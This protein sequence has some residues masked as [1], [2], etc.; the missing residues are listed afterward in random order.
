MKIKEETKKSIECG[1]IVVL[2]AATFIGIMVYKHNQCYDKGMYL[3]VPCPICQSNEV[4][5]LGD[6][7]GVCPDCGCNFQTSF[8]IEVAK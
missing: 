7:R 2:L 3:D 1:I 5:N 8:A 4:I 6:E